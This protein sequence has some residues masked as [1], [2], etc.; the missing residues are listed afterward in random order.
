MLLGSHCLAKTASCEPS[1]LLLDANY[2]SQYSLLK[3]LVIIPELGLWARELIIPFGMQLIPTLFWK[4]AIV[5]P[6]VAIFLEELRFLSRR[7]V[8]ET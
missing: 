1:S 6:K 2:A 7:L 3:L 8:F 5:S 4:V